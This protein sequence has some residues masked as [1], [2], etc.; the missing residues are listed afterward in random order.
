MGDK[1]GTRLV[2]KMVKGRHISAPQYRKYFCLE[3]SIAIIQA[4]LDYQTEQT[5]ALIQPK[6][7]QAIK[8]LVLREKKKKSDSIPLNSYLPGETTMAFEKFRKERG[9]SK[10]EAL[11]FIILNRLTK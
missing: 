11:N 1:K 5:R 7:Q 10:E 9:L 2:G 3:D 4:W 6:L 8:Q